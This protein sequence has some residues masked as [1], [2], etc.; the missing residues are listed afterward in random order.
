MTELHELAELLR[1]DGDWDCEVMAPAEG[2]EPRIRVEV[3]YSDDAMA[4]Y[5]DAQELSGV[6]V[7]VEITRRDLVDI[8][9][10]NEE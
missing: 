5:E 10:D 6:P 4:L 2:A 7:R 9:R 1:T 3:G 8:H